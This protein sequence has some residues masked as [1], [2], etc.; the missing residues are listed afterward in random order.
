[1][2]TIF[3][4]LDSYFV[5]V[6]VALAYAGLIA[7]SDMTPAMMALTLGFFGIVL[8]L[9][10][11]FRE[12]RL[13]A[14]ASRHAAVGEPD[15]L[16]ALA[17]KQ[18]TRRLRAKTRVPFQIYIAMAHELRGDRDAAK[19]AL[20][21]TDLDLLH[22]KVRRTWGAIHASLR[23]TLLTRDGDAA[24][25]RKVLEESLRPFLKYIPGAGAEV[26]LREAEARV[27]LAEAKPDEARPMFEA[28]AKDIR[29]GPATRAAC[30]YL[31][32]DHAAAAKLAPRTWMAT[33]VS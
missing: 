19:T 11:G 27:L 14:I 32:G 17:E 6:L 31:L 20:A 22:P 33:P 30:L 3:R 12:L 15:E 24:G 10:S 9:W 23:I 28:L 1:M 18:V 13:H 25:A 16:L 21:A 8:L 5:P 4:V 2:D 29:L 7:T 26:I